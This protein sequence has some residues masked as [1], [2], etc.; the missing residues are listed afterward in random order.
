MII[1]KD[2][3][4]LLTP[5]YKI[6]FDNL[7]TLR[8]RH[9]LQYNKSIPHYFI[10]PF[11]LNL[12][13]YKLN[14]PNSNFIVKEDNFFTNIDGYNKLMMSKDLYS[15]LLEKA[16]YTCIL[17]PDAIL[18]RDISKIDFEQ[19][20][21]IG[22]VW[23]KG[24]KINLKIL[25]KNRTFLEKINSRL[26]KKSVIYIGNG[27]LSIRNNSTFL[28]LSII[29][30]LSDNE[31]EPEDVYLSY[32]LKALSF[33]F[34]S[35]DF[36][37]QIFGEWIVEKLTTEEVLELYGVHGIDKVSNNIESEIFKKIIK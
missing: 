6:T 21:Y 22:S 31:Y 29:S 1:H 14:F 8:M 20:D 28:L 4:I 7:E 27:G 18:F 26:S 30:E 34:P 5:I 35:V 37:N 32:I 33:R 23:P 24:Y 25:K 36:C 19:F 9:S 12:D 16:N 11:N 15:D 2:R 17:Q 13:W 3:I 10:H